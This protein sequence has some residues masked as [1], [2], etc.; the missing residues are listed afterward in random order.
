MLAATH[1]GL[2]CTVCEMAKDKP[3]DWQCR[4]CEKGEDILGDRACQGDAKRNFVSV[5]NILRF[6]LQ[7]WCTNDAAII[8]MPDLP[9]PA[10]VL[11][12]FG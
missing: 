9:P 12:E 4:I 3:S 5:A 6:N 7:R 2:A 10:P 8:G 1:P 11:D